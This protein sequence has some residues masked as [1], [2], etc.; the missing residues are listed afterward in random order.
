M[1]CTN[2]GKTEAVH[3]EHLKLCD[4]QKLNDMIGAT[5]T[6]NGG[7]GTF[8]YKLERGK[9]TVVDWAMR[10]FMPKDDCK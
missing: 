5:K 1:L 8:L 10:V 6:N 9:I 7:F 2:T 4:A 3:L